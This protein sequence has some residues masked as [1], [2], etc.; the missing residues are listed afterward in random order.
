MGSLVTASAGQP[1]GT[2]PLAYPAPGL[3]S[4][5]ASPDSAPFCTPTP[6]PPPEG[7]PQ[8]ELTFTSLG[9]TPCKHERS[10]LC[11]W[12]CA[13]RHALPLLC[14]FSKRQDQAHIR[15][16][17]WCPTEDTLLVSAQLGTQLSVAFLPLG[18]SWSQ[19]VGWLPQG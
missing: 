7:Q 14:C 19:I 8:L 17:A 12:P 6:Q 1:L 2:T 3:S 18:S 15:A 4:S 13:S 10:E 11:R 16:V 9:K 5:L